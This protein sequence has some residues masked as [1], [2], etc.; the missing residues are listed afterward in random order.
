MPAKEEERKKEGEKSEKASRGGGR[1]CCRTFCTISDKY[2]CMSDVQADPSCIPALLQLGSSK[3]RRV[4]RGGIA[5]EGE[6]STLAWHDGVHVIHARVV[7][8]ELGNLQQGKLR[9]RG[10][11]WG[12]AHRL[13]EVRLVL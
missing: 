6:G 11:S 12:C 4:E 1:S 2:R 3:K 10:C 8:G 5:G 9:R 13:L 7:V